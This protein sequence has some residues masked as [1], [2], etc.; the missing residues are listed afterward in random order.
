MDEKS[1]EKEKS[2]L[3]GKSYKCPVCDEKFTSLGVRSG[4]V[5]SEGQD[6]DLR[7]RSSSIDSIKYSIILCPHCGYAALSQY[8]STVTV[9][10][11]KTIEEGITPNYDGLKGQGEVVPEYYSDEEAL[12]R[13][14][15][16]LANCLVK[17]CKDSEKGNLYL[18]MGWLF[19]GRRERLDKDNAGYEKAA[20]KLKAEEDKALKQALDFF[21]KARMNEDYPIGGMDE[22][23]L[24]YLIAALALGAG[25]KETASKMI[26]QILVSRT[27]NDRI[28]DKARDLKEEVAKLEAKE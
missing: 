26:G 16:A 13:F 21:I 24:E 23:T 2:L 25:E 3:V 7:P 18:R 15:V 27:V 6:R 9:H 20:A 12:R 14:R 28:K 22:P 8:F 19:R 10:Q 4:K 17:K 11:R 1:L 5:R